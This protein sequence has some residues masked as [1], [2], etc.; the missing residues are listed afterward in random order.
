MHF[1]CKNMGSIPFK[2]NKMLQKFEII[3]KI[4]RSYLIKLDIKKRLQE[5]KTI[6]KKL[7]TYLIR[8]DLKKKLQEVTAIS[9]VLGVYL[10]LV[11]LSI[12]TQILALLSLRFLLNYSSLFGVSGE[13]T[14]VLFLLIYC[15]LLG[16]FLFMLPFILSLVLYRLISKS[17]E[18]DWRILTTVIF[19]LVF[20]YWIFTGYWILYC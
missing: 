13:N 20:P 2:E 9:K 11:V 14:K 7:Q 18:I 16:I 6:W 17:K 12:I 19:M 1:Q 3:I 4:L 15:L 10:G 5:F 8:I